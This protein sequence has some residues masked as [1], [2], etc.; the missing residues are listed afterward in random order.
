MVKIARMEVE[1]WIIWWAYACAVD[2]GWAHNLCSDRLY[3][4]SILSAKNFVRAGQTTV[5]QEVISW[6]QYGV[7]SGV[8]LTL[9]IT[10]C[11]FHSRDLLTTWTAFLINYGVC[12]T[13]VT[14]W[15]ATSVILDVLFYRLEEM[16]S[17]ISVWQKER[18]YLADEID[19]LSVSW[20]YAADCIGY[21]RNRMQSQ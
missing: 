19:P 7:H 20:H 9:W 17:G 6:A 18:K 16:W 8:L 13:L 11:E 10:A 21:E 14:L 3:S 15:I 12:M 2:L 5:H 4:E 1:T